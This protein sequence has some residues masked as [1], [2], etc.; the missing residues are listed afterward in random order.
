MAIGVLLLVVLLSFLVPVCLGVEQSR[1][2]LLN[3]ILSQ[4]IYLWAAYLQIAPF[5]FFGTTLSGVDFFTV[6]QGLSDALLVDNA[7]VYTYIVYGLFYFLCF[8][9]ITL[10]YF[11]KG[12]TDSVSRTVSFVLLLFVVAGFVENY[13]YNIAFNIYLPF[14]YAWVRSYLP[15]KFVFLGGNLSR[16]L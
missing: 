4:R 10:L 9:F 1:D 16:R 12:P 13:T 11:W 15:S 8:L 5:S 14:I 6:N 2:N 3:S 7:F